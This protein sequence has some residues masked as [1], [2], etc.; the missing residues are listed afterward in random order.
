MKPLLARGVLNVAGATTFDEYRTTIE[1]DAALSRRF[2][3][4]MVFEPSLSSTISILR[5]LRGRYE[6]F[7]GI[8]ISDAALVTA[9]RYAERYLSERKNP[10]ASIDLVDE[11]A[12]ALRLQQESKPEVIETLE[13]EVMTMQI[14]LAS[15][16][17]ESDLASKARRE[18]IEA[19]LE[20]KRTEMDA[21]TGVWNEEKRKLEEV[22]E[23]KE[24]L[25]E[26]NVELERMTR[27]GNLQ[28][29]AELQY[30][31]IPELKKRLPKED[32]GGTMVED[33]RSSSKAPTSLLHDRVTSEDIAAVVARITGIPVR[34]LLRGDRERLLH[35]EEH[36]Q[37]RIVGQD[38][39]L[40]SMAEA[41]RLSRA[42][43][44]NAE[45]PLASFLMLGQTGTGKTESC[46]ALADFLFDSKDALI[47]L[48]C[49]ELSEAHA[50]SKLVGAPPGY[51]GFDQA[52]QLTERVR[53]K[54]YSI[55]LF[56]EIEKAAKAVQ[57]V[58][59]QILDEG[60][61]TDSQGR[62][63]DF[64]QTIV[65]MTSNLGAEVL[66]EPGA[67]TS[68]GKLTETSRAAMMR[69]VQASLAPELIN[70][71]DEQLYYNRLSR[72][73]LRGIVD[74]RL[75]EIRTR[76]SDR[77]VQ[78]VVR[79]H[80]KEWL[81]TNGYSEVYGARPLNRLIQKAL[82]NP[83]AKNII[84][85][86]IRDGDVVTVDRNAGEDG[87]AVVDI[88][89]EQPQPPQQQQQSS[90]SPGSDAYQGGLSADSGPEVVEGEPV[91]R[92]R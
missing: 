38:E 74:I 92:R 13:R 42:G 78:L 59:L 68:D 36:L 58:L 40:R 1:K 8:G 20:A 50:V 56:D 33:E 46:R 12:S 37:Q 16:R 7:H 14:E 26:I 83:L 17:H 75:A 61:L 80:A 23:V 90:R 91:P 89:H 88:Q 45:K 57:M 41:I 66:A 28:R 47:K 39:A 54:P 53:R 67:T 62:T 76:L 79:D 10:D 25:E 34:N 24:R 71:I 9:A 21:L 64:R 70:R 29:V 31:I 81:A 27:E 5:G 60:K 19:E 73:S 65:V 4:V 87:I 30:A 32:D 69:A 55:I 72:D 85:G 15:L 63:V 22:R 3:P 2:Q 43:L 51:V 6:A 77:R 48:D 82:L 11:A 18:T 52:T 35:I 44:Q 84:D 86:T 49:S